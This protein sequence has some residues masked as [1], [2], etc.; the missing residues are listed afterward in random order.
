MKQIANLGLGLWKVNKSDTENVV[1]VAIKLGYRY[2]DCACD[3]R[4]EIEVGKVIH[5]A[6]NDKL[7]TRDGLWVTSM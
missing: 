4:N 3:Y 6:I 1:Y 5:R 2:L 7:V